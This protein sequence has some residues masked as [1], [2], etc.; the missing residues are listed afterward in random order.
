MVYILQYSEFDTS[1]ILKFLFI[2]YDFDSYFF[3]CF[4]VNAFNCLSKRPLSKELKNF[5]P[6]PKMIFENN[7]IVSIFII[8]TMVEYIHLLQPILMSLYIFSCFTCWLND[9]PLN[10]LFTILSAIIN[11][12]I[13]LSGYF[14]S[15]III[16]TWP[17]DCQSIICRQRK[18]WIDF[19]L[20]LL[21]LLRA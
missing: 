9:M 8:I 20:W 12:A 3:F 14:L 11:L 10:F 21:K 2:S 19:D 13:K 6:I 7:L 18:L 1:L 17:I 5:I 4:M 16:K 15:L